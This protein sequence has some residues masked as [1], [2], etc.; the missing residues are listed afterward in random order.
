M[1]QWGD[2]DRE[3]AV[4]DPVVRPDP[5]AAAGADSGYRPGHDAHGR[6]WLSKYAL[7][8]LGLLLVLVFSLTLRSTFPTSRTVDSILSDQS[9]VAMLAL[10]EMV[11]VAVGQ[12]D[13]SV[14]YGLGLMELLAVGL[15]FRDHISWPV[16]VIIVLLAG[17]VVGALNGLLVTVARIDSFI[18][19]LGLGYV[20]YGIDNWY[21]QGEQVVGN[22]FPAGFANINDAS[23]LGIPLPAIYV[24]ILAAILWIVMDFLPAGRYMY[25]IGSNRRAAELSGLRV[26]RYTLAAFIAAGVI[27]A[28]AAVVLAANLQIGES[29]V[30]PEFLLPAFVGALLGATTIRPGR[31]NVWGTVVAVLVLGI[32]IAGLEQVGS[33]FYVDPLFDGGTLIIAVGAAGYAA[34]R[35]MARRKRQEDE[36]MRAHYP[37]QVD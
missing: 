26:R 1:N 22:N 25:A 15:L 34:R 4:T 36:L 7:G 11:V 24:V 13:L 16:I 3:P 6:Q 28:A 17:A 33:A 8:I 37:K 2:T 35:Q 19:T 18:A 27:V 20:L 10:A 9:T 14:G 21:S 23:L 12:Y 32:G 5:S 29:D 30:G 31:V